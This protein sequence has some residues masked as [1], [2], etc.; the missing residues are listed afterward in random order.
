MKTEVTIAGHVYS[1]GWCEHQYFTAAVTAAMFRH[2][3]AMAALV[4][5]NGLYCTSEFDNSCLSWAEPTGELADIHTGDEVGAYDS[6]GMP[7]RTEVMQLVICDDRIRW[8][9]QPKDCGTACLCASD[10][11]MI[12]DLGAAFG[13]PS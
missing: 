8:E 11:V 13:A 9:W 6:P 4:R 10:E 3:E 2:I 5:A 12:A 1:P 7:L